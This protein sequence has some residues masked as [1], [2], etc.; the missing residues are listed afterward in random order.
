MNSIIEAMIRK[1]GLNNP[2]TNKFLTEDE[3]KE[4][5]WGYVL[6]PYI[7]SEHSEESSN[8]YSE[9][10]NQ[11]HNQHKYCPE[12]GCEH[13]TTTLVA[14]ILNWDK[15]D[16]YKDNNKCVCSKC[17]DVHTTHDRVS[18]KNNT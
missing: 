14:Y 6:V 3:I 2:Q 1:G 12:C 5:K 11:Y 8:R 9:F 7:L 15:R 18:N 13:Y 17:G 4:G 16:E 10:M